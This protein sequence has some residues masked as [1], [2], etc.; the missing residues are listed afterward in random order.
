MIA[1][2]RVLLRCMLYMLMLPLALA[3]PLALVICIF[4]WPM[5]P[6]LPESNRIQLASERSTDPSWVNSSIGVNSA[7]GEKV[8]VPLS[9]STGL[10][11]RFSVR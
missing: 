6:E 5:A 2:N 4:P 11:S 8:T 1:G 9:L 10:G 3:L 7:Y